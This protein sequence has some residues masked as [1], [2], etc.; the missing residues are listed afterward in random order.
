MNFFRFIVNH[1]RAT[2]SIML[3][4]L[5]AGAMSRVSM[6]VEMA[7]NVTL[8]VVMVMVRHDGI[9]PEDGARLLVR[10]IEK[11]LKTL[12]GIEEIKA[13]ARESMVIVT[14][15]FESSENIKN[16]VADVREAV[17][18]AKAEFPLDTKEPIVNELSPSP[19]PTII[20]TFSGE[21]V[22]ERELYSATKYYQRQL[23]MLPNVLTA[24]ISGHR[25]EVVDVVI[26]PSRLEQYGLR[27]DEI[28]Q[29]VRVN[30]LLIPAGEMDAAQGRFGIKVPAL[31]ETAADIRTL[32]IRNNSDGA[33]TLGDVADVR[34]TFKDPNGYSILNGKK[35]IALDVRKRITANEIRTVE[36]VRET[37]AQSRDLFS[38]DMEIGYTFD[39]SLMTNDMISE[40]QG[41]II[42]AMCLVLILVVATLGVKS[43]LLVGFGIPFCLLGALIV[44]NSLGYSFNFMV[45]FGLLLSLGMLI[46]G[47]IVVVEFASTKAAAGL[48]TRDAYI[49]AVQ[50]MAVPVIASTGTTLAAFLPLLFWPGVSGDF[51]SYLP[52]TVFAVLGW[53]LMYALIF[54]PT[55]GI[56]LA[57]RRG[58]RKKLPE[59]HQS[60]ESAKTLF[61]PLIDV[62]LKA[63]NPIIKSPIKFILA[64]MLVIVGIFFAYG[65][66]NGGQDF[67][68][69]IESQYGMLEVRAQGNLSID[70]QREITLK[71]HEIVSEIEGVNNLYGYSSNDSSVV[72][73]TDVSRDQISSFLVEL[74]PREQ[75][76]KGSDVVFA[77]I[78]E[79]MSGLPGI[80]ATGQEMETGPPTGKDIQIQVSSS[81]RQALYK[82]VSKVRQWIDGNV[83][84]IRNLQDTLPLAGIQWEVEVDRARAAMLGVN[85]ADV[86]NMVQMVT[87]GIVI[88]E[89]RPDDAD[90]EIEIRLR[91]P[92]QDRQLTTIDNL[93]VNTPN[94]PVSISSFSQ[95][96]DM[97]ETVLILGNSKDGYLADNQTNEIGA[98]IDQQDFGSSVKI[99]FRGANEEQANAAAFLSTAF[100]LAMSLM[101]IM[102]VMQFNSFYQAGLILFSVVLST[103]G[104]LLGLIASQATFSTVLT[105][106]GIV[107]L[108]GIVVNN[109]IVLI[110]TYNYLRRNNSLLTASEAVLVAAKSRF[111]PVMLTTVTTIVGLLPLANG[112]SIDIVHRSYTVG[113]MVASWWQPLA[114]AIVNGLAFSTIL[115]LLLTPAML[116]I[117]DIISKRLGFRIADHQFEDEAS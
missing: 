15:E 65:K 73:G 38:A 113:G 59:D 52:I 117:P 81:D 70:E 62:S 89:F 39:S 16:A 25:D 78:R 27:I 94:G 55:L 9:S 110:D 108:A 46:D 97:L 29:A 86:G 48:S 83:E 54:A 50:R 71:V 63:L 19:E 80:Y 68:A 114:S 57:R 104:V 2:L 74:F 69:Q 75:R 11:E 92:K 41:N 36:A 87:G 98:W 6:P 106:V 56:A 42:T 26:D 1:T 61:Q 95:R 109:N 44:V 101:M 40:L 90:G 3:L 21:N 10:P 85:V 31:I 33:I 4:I 107:A 30:N 60:E 58:K 112:I 111:R 77:A 99:R 115:T 93:N 67:F 103:A 53:S 22:T 28:I 13:T 12:D 96:Y 84:G 88:G 76:E 14:A 20:I 5:V 116:L 18:R 32:P 8:P 51:M 43:G 34:R 91:Y 82:T 45:M 49:S 100:S 66:F 23:E 47:A 35:T 7:P 79:R 17:D 102:L 105:G 37:V 24:G 72:Y 64:S